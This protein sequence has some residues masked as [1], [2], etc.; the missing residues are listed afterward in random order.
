MVAVQAAGCAPIV[1]AFEAGVEHAP[2]W[3]NA[4]TV[5]SGI[6]VPA[7]VGDFLIL[8]AVRQSGGFAIAV[9][10]AAIAAALDEVARTEGFLLCPEGAATCAALKQSLAEGRVGKAE[11]AVL[12]NCATGLKYPLPPVTRTLDRTRPIDFAAL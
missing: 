10:D 5:A 9:S 11:R 6:R 3:E 1:R 8:R 12:F 4:A 7:A 2:R